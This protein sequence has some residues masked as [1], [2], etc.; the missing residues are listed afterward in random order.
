MSLSTVKLRH[1]VKKLYQ[2]KFKTNINIFNSLIIL[3]LFGMLLSLGGI[4][5]QGGGYFNISYYTADYMICFTMIWAFIVAIQLMA[6]EQQNYDFLFV[7]NRF[8]SHLANGFFLL[9]I[10]LIGA[11]TALLSRYLSKV[12]IHFTFG[13]VYAN[14]VV[15]LVFSDYIFGFIATWLFAFIFSM[16]GY[17]VGA[18]IQFNKIFTIILPVFII[19][20]LI[21]SAWSGKSNL[22]IGLFEFYFVEPSFLIY[23]IKVII[24]SGILFATVVLLTNRLEVKT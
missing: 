4:G 24:T 12:I 20:Y 13:T 9:T 17:T 7:T 15:M 19:G 3:Q 23:L 21:F 11:I 8:A 14:E 5:Q 6:K 2:F 10:S 1:I 18:I 16:L 22:L